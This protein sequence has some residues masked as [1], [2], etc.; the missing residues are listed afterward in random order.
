ME[1]G[2]G[3][4]RPLRGHGEQLIHGTVNTQ[5]RGTMTSI[6]PSVALGDNKS[7]LLHVGLC[8]LCIDVA[9]ILRHLDG[10]SEAV[11][12]FINPHNSHC[13]LVSFFGTTS[14]YGHWPW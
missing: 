10:I 4:E 3:S 14:R 1:K 12:L 13:L 8:R 9:L 5:G 6:V 11:A 2:A 7:T